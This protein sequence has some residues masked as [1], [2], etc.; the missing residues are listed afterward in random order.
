MLF[1]LNEINNRI[2][3][4]SGLNLSDSNR[5]QIC[6]LWRPAGFGFL[7]IEVR[8]DSDFKNQKS[9]HL[10][11][12]TSKLNKKTQYLSKVSSRL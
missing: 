9:D 8:M 6:N 12:Y 5:I 1:V 4:D 11:S 3:S 2:F 7:F 10:F